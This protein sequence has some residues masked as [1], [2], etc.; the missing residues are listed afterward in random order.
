MIAAGLLTPGQAYQAIDWDIIVLLLGMFVLSGSLRLA[1][2][3]EWA[4]EVVLTRV[5]TPTAVLTALV[6]VS[7]L[8]S[9]LL[10]NDTVWVMLTPLVIARIERRIQ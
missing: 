10:V 9:A 7:G 1:G 5:R 6:S 2:F 8:L 4:A 3:F